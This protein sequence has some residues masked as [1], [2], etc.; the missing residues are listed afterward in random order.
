[1]AD[2]QGDPSGETRAARRP[3]TIYLD[4]SDLSYLV[5]GR[6]PAGANVSPARDR[7]VALL[8]DERVRLVVSFVHLAEMAIDDATA[9]AALRWLDTGPPIWCFT[10]AAEAI[11]RAEL[12]G[13]SLTIDAEPL[14]RGIV[15][16]LRLR[17]RAPMPSVS[18]GTVARGVRG[19]ALA[20]AKAEELSKRAAA[21]RPGTTAKEHAVAM[22]EQRR[23]ADRVLRGEAHDLPLVARVAASVLMPIARWVTARHELTLDDVR[24]HARLPPGCSWFAGCVPPDTWRDAAKR[25]KLSPADAPA[26]ALRVAI[27]AGRSTRPSA[28]YDVQHLAYAARCDFATIDGPNFRATARVRAAL[29]RPTFF[30]TARLD[31]V[32]GALERAARPEPLG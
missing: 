29:A 23:V 15:E 6:G 31:E 8:T 7:L 22:R 12:L 5:K 13:E 24:A 17:L 27:S 32:V 30:E 10:T 9:D 2:I 16:S 4:T 19:I 21:R 20:W 1:M 11:F 18:A 26:S 3:V 14:T 25:V 28:V